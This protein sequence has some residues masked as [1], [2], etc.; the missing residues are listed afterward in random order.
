MDEESFLETLPRHIDQ[1]GIVS[2]IGN[3][4][5]NAVD[6]VLEQESGKR[7]IWVKI[8]ECENSIWITVR[9]NGR[10]IPDEISDRIFERG[11]STKHSYGTNELKRTD[12][13]EKQ[14][15]M[16]LYITQNHVLSMSGNIRFRVEDGTLFEVNIPTL[17]M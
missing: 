9:D 12:N 10:G 7:E 15:G 4:I 17:S 1:N 3:L 8:W 5:D 14:R 2:I 16:G 13:D 6:T 11:F